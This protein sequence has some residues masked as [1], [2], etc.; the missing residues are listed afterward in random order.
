MYIV[1][2]FKFEIKNYSCSKPF[3]LKLSNFEKVN[4]NIGYNIGY[5]DRLK[6]MS[7][8]NLDKFK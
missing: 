2:F 6:I 7:N 4:L 8:D 3:N 5:S 1:T